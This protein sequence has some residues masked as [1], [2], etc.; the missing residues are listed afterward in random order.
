MCDLVDQHGE[1]HFGILNNWLPEHWIDK[2]RS[3]VPPCG[4]EI[5]DVFY[6]AGTGDGDFS[7]SEM[8]RKVEGYNNMAIDDESRLIWELEVP[9][10]CRS[11]LW[12]LKHERL[13][14]NIS[15]SRKGLG[16]AG[17]GLCNAVC[18]DTSHIWRSLVPSNITEKLFSVDIKNWIT[19]NLKY[20]D[21][22]NEN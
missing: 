7:V 9:E 6:F 10:R 22:Q 11:F 14:T 13:L 4:G 5:S 2:F 15:K 21:I 1:W 20:C 16:N 19:I 8:F 18:E 3:C 17:C 12:L